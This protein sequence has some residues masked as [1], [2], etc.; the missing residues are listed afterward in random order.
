MRRRIQKSG[1]ESLPAHEVVE[2]LLSY[3]LPR[4]NLNE[5]AHALIER[6]QTIRSLLN[7]SEEEIAEVRGVGVSTAR[8]LRAFGDAVKAYREEPDE[9]TVVL[10]TRADAA[11]YARRL[12]M[13]DP[14]PQI[15][16][17]L[18]SNYGDV[19]LT[20]RIYAGPM[21]LTE[22]TRDLILKRSLRYHANYIVLFARR[23]FH[24]G[25]ILPADRRMVEEL[26]KMLESV[27]VKMMDYLV[28]CPDRVVSL[29]YDEPKK[30]PDVRN[31]VHEGEIIGTWLE[32]VGDVEEAR[33][34]R[35]K[36]AETEKRYTIKKNNEARLS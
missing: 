5:I 12:L 19:I 31:L 3:Y 16:M 29:K 33:T 18:V 27:K 15:W 32:D 11:N 20:N 1:L 7:A 28:V 2:F 9:E 4:R 10:R 34:Y 35:V 30:A 22:K 21:W 6:F 25:G 17:S 8:F 23:G 26:T 14:R 36:R 24:I 13:D